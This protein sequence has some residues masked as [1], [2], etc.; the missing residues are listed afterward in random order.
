MTNELPDSL[1]IPG[2]FSEVYDLLGSML[3]WAPTF[4]DE[5]GYFP[6]RNIDTRFH[7]LIEGL[8]RVRGKLGEERYTKLGDLTARAKALFI[9]DPKDENGKADQGRDLLF[10]IEAIIQDARKRRVKAKLKD[11]EGEVTG[12]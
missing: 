6:E 12:D 5:R 8:E 11:D 7:Q 4:V 9:E 1:Y 10:E 2:S 3:L